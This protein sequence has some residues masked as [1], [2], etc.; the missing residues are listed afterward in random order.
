MC[1]ARFHCGRL[2]SHGWQTRK[3]SEMDSTVILTKNAPGPGGPYSQ[4]VRRGNILALSGQAGVSPVS[5]MIVE[6]VDE[7]IRQ[8]MNNLQAVLEEAGASFADVVMIRAYLTQQGHFRELNNVFK[9]FI[10]DPPPART[11]AYV[12]L[13]PGMLVELDA[14]AVVE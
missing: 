1:Y 7:Q 8:A 5:G 6:G 12:E 2:E 10:L 9:E 3:E 4:A 14:L 11:T 13:P